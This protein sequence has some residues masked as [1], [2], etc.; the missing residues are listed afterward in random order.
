MVIDTSFYYKESKT[1][2]ESKSDKR[3]GKWIE[4]DLN[5]TIYGEYNYDSI[6][7][8]RGI[9]VVNFPDG[10]K[11]FETEYSNYG[12]VRASFFL[13]NFKT[14][15]IIP[16]SIIPLEIY[17][18]IWAIDNTI[19]RQ[20]QN[21]K[22]VSDDDR[23]PSIIITFGFSYFESLMKVPEVL[24]KY[25]FAGSLIIWN[26]DQRIRR[27]YNYDSGNEYRTSY[28]YYGKRIKRKDEYLNDTLISKT[29][30]N[31]KGEP[32]K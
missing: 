30:F 28:I 3:I 32:K 29:K 11:R 13:N 4:T 31:K 24:K 17:D 20:F 10:S 26:E 23:S 27:S 14:L 18:R 8:P 19:F 5:G 25:Q 16:N 2:G 15:N 7:N 12:I 22:T 6:G 21:I 1:V 9:W